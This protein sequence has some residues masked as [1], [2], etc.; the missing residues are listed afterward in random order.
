MA[1]RP[2]FVPVFSGPTL[3]AE[4]TYSFK[5]HGGFSAKQKI[6][7]REALHAAAG[8][9]GYSPLLE[10]S[11]KSA[12]KIG[13]R[14]SAFN[15][16][17]RYGALE[18]PIECLFQGSKVFEAGGPYIDLFD[19]S[20]VEAKKDERLRSSGA[21]TGF[22]FMG[23][24]FPLYPRSV[25]YDWL[26]LQALYPHRSPFL[27][28]NFKP[29]VGFTDIEF[30][31]NKSFNCQARSCAI[32]RSLQVRGL[33]DEAM[34]SFSAFRALHMGSAESLQASPSQYELLPAA[35]R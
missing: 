18:A 20:P 1:E 23:E 24:R 25:F 32:F 28:K 9:A 7:N 21:L 5:W 12:N 3:C 4:I 35:I 29:F 6:R 27:E 33:L 8:E 26:F 16:K 11:S 14:L 10:T 13:V 31:P 17:L 34:T 30:N 2:I 15:L 22:R 19:A